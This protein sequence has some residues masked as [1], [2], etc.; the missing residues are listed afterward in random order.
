MFV[1]LK[2]FIYFLLL[3]T[4]I[5]TEKKMFLTYD[6]SGKY[7]IEISTRKN[8]TSIVITAVTTVFPM[9]TQS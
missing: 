3:S 5:Q 7:N 4:R 6:K 8:H 1:H 9:M 2:P